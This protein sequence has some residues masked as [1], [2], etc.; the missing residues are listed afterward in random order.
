MEPTHSEDYTELELSPNP[1]LWPEEFDYT[2]EDSM[3]TN[4]VEF[5]YF[6]TNRKREILSAIYTQRCA[7]PEFGII[8]EV[9]A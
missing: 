6:I 2:P 4:T 1:E 8:L 3:E 7:N 5:Q 9:L